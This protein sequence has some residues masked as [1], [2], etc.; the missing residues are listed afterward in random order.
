MLKLIIFNLIAIIHLL[1]WVFVLFG[2][3]NINTAWVNLFIIVPVIYILH[4]LPFHIIQKTKE[5]MYRDDW[6]VKVD[7]VEN[8]VFVVKYFNKLSTYCNKHCFASPISPQGMLIFGALSSAYVL[9]NNC[10]VMKL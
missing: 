6:K 3:V 5:K 9:L 4:I 2:F 8:S 7:R 10:N 1:I